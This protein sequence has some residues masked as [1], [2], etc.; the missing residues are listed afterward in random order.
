MWANITVKM[1][2]K[3]I[4][5]SK[6]HILHETLSS[7]TSTTNNRVMFYH[8]TYIKNNISQ[9]TNKISTIKTKIHFVFAHKKRKNY[10]KVTSV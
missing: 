5:N 3:R 8:S 4:S 7:Q 2:R 1:F 9:I 6:N 10:R